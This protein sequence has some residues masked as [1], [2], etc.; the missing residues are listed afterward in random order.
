MLSAGMKIVVVYKTP[1]NI[2]K[3]F[4]N[5]YVVEFLAA[6]DAGNDGMFFDFFGVKASTA[7]GPALF[8]RRI[9]VPIIFALDIREDIYKHNIF[10]ER[11]EY[12][13]TDNKEEDIKNL[14]N[15][16]IKNGKVFI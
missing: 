5:K 9:D 10:I 1:K 14:I 6:Q 13:F 2:F 3:A 15:I 7:I 12:K 8:S 4:D 16:L 11:V